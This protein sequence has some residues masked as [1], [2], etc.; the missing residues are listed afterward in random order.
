VF[1][2]ANEAMA[3]NTNYYTGCGLKTAEI[4][5]ERITLCVMPNNNVFAERCLPMV[6]IM[7][8][9]ASTHRDL[10]TIL[11]TAS[12]HSLSDQAPSGI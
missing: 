3:K 4:A 11:Q 6:S 2:A 10:E 5:T 1:S 8:L 7:Q 12:L 9:G